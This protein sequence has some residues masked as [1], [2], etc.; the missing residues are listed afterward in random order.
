MKKP[1]TLRRQTFRRAQTTDFDVHRRPF[2]TC[3]DDPRTPLNLHIFAVFRP[4]CLIVNFS[5]FLPLIVYSIMLNFFPQLT[6]I[7]SSFFCSPTLNIATSFR[8]S[9]ASFFSGVF[10]RHL[11]ELLV[12][13]LAFHLRYG[14]RSMAGED[15]AR[16]KQEDLEVTWTCMKLEHVH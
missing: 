4:I 1:M 16:Q 9:A 11:R 8:R 15:V 6:I 12:G 7:I 2:L 14:R 3:T 5:T 10:G 13:V